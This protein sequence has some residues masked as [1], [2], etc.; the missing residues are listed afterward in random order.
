MGCLKMAL[1]AGV[2]AAASASGA[3]AFAQADT[4]MIE[5]IVVRGQRR[6]QT[7]FET[8][9]QIT[10][11]SRDDLD[12]ANVLTLIDLQNKIPNTYFGGGGN[13]GGN[14]ISIRGVGGSATVFGEEPVAVFVD[15]Q[16]VARGIATSALLDMESIEVLRG[17]QGTLY[18]RNATAGAVLLRSARPKLDEA[19]GFAK[20]NLAQFGEERYEL[21]YGAP[22]V[23]GKLA[24]RVAALYNE[25]TGFARNLAIPGDHLDG[26]E[27]TRL[28]ASL[29]WA[30]TDRTEVFALVETA[31]GTSRAPAIRYSL[32]TS[33]SIRIPAAQIDTLK[34]RD[35]A[36]NTPN[37][38]DLEDT[39][40]VVSAKMKFEGFDVIADSSYFYGNVVGETDS[41][42]TG[43][44]LVYNAGRFQSQLYTQDLRVVSNGS[45]PLDW[46]V[47]LSA[48]EDKFQ[49]PYFFIRNQVSPAF[50]NLGFFSTQKA[51]AYAAYAEGTYRATD[52][53]SLTLGARATHERKT[54][55]VDRLFRNLTTGAIALDPPPYASKASWDNVSPRAIVKYAINDSVN[56]YASISRGF[57]GGG[58]NAFGA[59]AAFDPETITSYE[60]GTKL[61]LLDGRLRVNAAAF[62]YDYKDLQVRLGVPGGG[63]AIASAEGAKVTGAEFDFSYRVTEGLTLSGS[64]ALLDTKYK[65]FLTPNLVGALVSA[66]GND[67]SRAPKAQYSIAAEYSWPIGDSLSASLSASAHHTGGVVFIPTDQASAAW[68][69]KAYTEVDLRASVAAADGQWEV[70]VFLQNATDTFVVTSITAAANF[71]I[72]GFN[73]P[74]KLGVELSK[75][76]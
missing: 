64:G 46:I 19:G 59:D 61:R 44:T 14:T 40:A 7:S 28:R 56:L 26:F 68:R 75:R 32:N 27:N 41:D 25:R 52:R 71:P 43:A 18:G 45:G 21:A 9:V 17:P 76:F 37:Y 2:S 8:P 13:Y 72:A 48:V 74:R 5:E 12:K 24:V 70:A 47:G 58:F 11:L 35:F 1:L 33:N 15:D 31:T 10:A 34:D 51:K 39:R 62:N 4:G 6:E 49:M 22:L 23:S 30:P 66:G 54:V 73:E 69:A 53:L 29:L 20:V 57:K 63:V 38:S 55:Y 16:F 67:L 42:G 50:G 60:A 36:L 3:P 65:T